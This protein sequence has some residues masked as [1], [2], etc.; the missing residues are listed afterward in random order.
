[1]CLYSFCISFRLIA[2]DECSGTYK[3]SKSC[4]LF[5]NTLTGESKQG[6]RGEDRGYARKCCGCRHNARVR[7]IFALKQFMEVLEQE[8]QGEEH[9]KC[10]TK[11]PKSTSNILSCLSNITCFPTRRAVFQVT[12]HDV[13]A[14]MRPL[15]D[16]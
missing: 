12:A 1:M 2:I 9:L 11:S 15:D 8:P 5:G 4:V 13:F 3:E 16:L 14:R 6:F 7:L 10:A